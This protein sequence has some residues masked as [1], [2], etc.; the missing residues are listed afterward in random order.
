MRQTAEKAEEGDDEAK[1]SLTFDEFMRAHF[2]DDHSGLIIL[3]VILSIFIIIGICVQVQHQ[4]QKAFLE[5]MLPT[6]QE[7]LMKSIVAQESITKHKR[8]I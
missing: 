3:G 8:D 5:R 1:K 7:N 4:H 2:V 6:A